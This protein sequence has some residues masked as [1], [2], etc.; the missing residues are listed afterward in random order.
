M[1]IPPQDEPNE[2][3]DDLEDYFS[4]EELAIIND[5][6]PPDFYDPFE[7]LHLTKQL[8]WMVKAVIILIVAYNIFDFS[9][10]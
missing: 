5:D 10:S 1:D 3:D 9:A 6:N 2:T 7:V 8:D 4:E